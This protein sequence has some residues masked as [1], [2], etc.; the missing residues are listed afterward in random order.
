MELTDRFC[1][2]LTYAARLHAGQRRKATGEPYVAHLLG[3]AAIALEYGADEDAAIAALLHDAAE[4]QGGQATLDEIAQRFGP[5]VAEIVAACSDALVQPKPPW[6]ARKEATIAK[7]PTAPAAV[8]LV[9]SA[10][11]LHNVESLRRAYQRQGDAIWPQFRG[12][13][14][15]TLWYFRGLVAALQQAGPAPLTDELARAVAAFAAELENAK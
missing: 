8:R 3:V 9:A 2:A 1:D 5:A 11:K 10:D 12:G 4:D 6:R 7:L 15:G 13:R 14:E